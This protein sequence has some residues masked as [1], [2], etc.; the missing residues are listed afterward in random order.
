MSLFDSIKTSLARLGFGQDWNLIVC[1]AVIGLL[2]ALGA[3]GFHEAVVAIERWSQGVQ[4]NWSPFLMPV[5]PVCG[6]LL[7][8]LLVHYFASAARGHGVPQVMD[9]VIRKKGHI[10]LRVGLVK[11]VASMCTVGSGGSAGVEGPIVQIGSTIGSVFGQRVGVPKQHL[12]TLVGCG[13]AAG[14]AA[15]FNAPI[16]GVFFALEI[17]LRDFSLKTFTPIVVASVFS[18]AV[19]QSVLRE[20]NAIFAAELAQYQFSF[21]ELPGYI[22]LGFVCAAVSVG[23]TK[24]LHLGED[25]FERLH[26]HPIVR[27]VAGAA[28]LGVVGVAAAF[29]LAPAGRHSEYP[30]FFGNGY[31]TIRIMLDGSYYNGET[32]G[33]GAS[34]AAA[35]N[36]IGESAG[37]HEPVRAHSA[38]HAHAAVPPPG[39]EKPVFWI[40]LLLC[41]CKAIGTTCTLGSGGSGGVFAPSLFL[42]ATAGAAYGLALDQFGL[43]P[44]GSTPA[45]YALVGMAAVLAGTTFSPLTAILMLFELTREPYVLLPI[46]IAA[47]IATSAA[48]IMMRDSIYTAKLRQA[49]VNVG[50][51]RDLSVLRRIP[52][53]SVKLTPLPPEPI[54]AS[55]PLSKLITLHANHHVPDFVAVDQGTGKYIG[56]VTGADIR[57]ALID[58]EAIPLLLV[59]ELVRD[60]L[61]T[62]NLDE[63]LD[64]V[65]DKFARLDVASLCVIDAEAGGRPI[66]LV[67]RAEVMKRY[68]RALEES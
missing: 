31:D 13:A 27:P 30:A 28:I 63:N 35:I 4:S 51:G 64:T 20:N 67:T 36:E 55:D 9:A 32:S 59:A 6:A 2:T 37:A 52:L 65:M 23:F 22:G 15:I 54:Y 3:V 14:I 17:I 45:S 43:L 50:S 47:I 44:A 60:S 25:F 42:G 21:L 58:R 11:T 19:M 18:T 38:G 49:G 5:I 48:Q 53:S 1:G 46:M 62:L 12:P 33:G 34:A 56:M 16:A 41:V 24:F 57:T 7:T 29:A 68:Q 39:L 8:G 10:P 26:L 66:G 40:I 61:P